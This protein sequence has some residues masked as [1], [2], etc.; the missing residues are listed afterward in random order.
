MA[1]FTRAHLRSPSQSN[2]PNRISLTPVLILSFHPRVNLPSVDFHSRLPMKTIRIF[3]PAP[4]RATCSAH[5]S[6]T[7]PRPVLEPI[8]PCTQWVPRIQWLGCE[9]PHSPPPSAEAKVAE[10]IPP[11][12]HVFISYEDYALKLLAKNCL[13]VCHFLLPGCKRFPQHIVRKSFTKV[14]SVFL[15]RTN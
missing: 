2:L 14:C 1:V 13:P 5:L 15:C 11:F 8:Q 3:L 12:P 10:V 7:P 6:P 4:M 9:G